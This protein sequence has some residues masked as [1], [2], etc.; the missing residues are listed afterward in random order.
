[1]RFITAALFVSLTILSIAA[2]EIGLR[3][4]LN[5]A[6]H[7]L[8]DHCVDKPQPCWY[9]IV[10][11][12]TTVA[13]VQ[14]LL[15]ETG[16]NPS[17]RSSYG[18]I[19]YG[20]FKPV[21]NCDLQAHYADST[22]AVQRLRF[23]DCADIR[24]GDLASLFGLPDSALADPSSLTLFYGNGTRIILDSPPFS[25]YSLVEGFEFR[26]NT[27]ILDSFVVDWQGFQ[28]PIWYCYHQFLQHGVDAC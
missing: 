21:I 8:N 19:G 18:I 3:Q 17:H 15:T 28:S 16:Y 26:S 6:L 9:G 5:P 13:E 22:G 27:R 25:L 14:R 11:G 2:R 20:V 7:S 23:Q 4:P 12:G 1:M 24:F 10:L